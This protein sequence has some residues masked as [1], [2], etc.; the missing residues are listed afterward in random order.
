VPIYGLINSTL[1]TARRGSVGSGTASA[2]KTRLILFVTA[3]L[4]HLFRGQRRVSYDRSK[5]EENG[6]VAW[7]PSAADGTSRL[8]QAELFITVMSLVA[9]RATTLPVISTT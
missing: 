1:R 4:P 7:S 8:L 5:F 2:V 3:E 6:P 9:T